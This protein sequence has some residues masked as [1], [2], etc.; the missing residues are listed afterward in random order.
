MLVVR[1][2]GRRTL[3]S[4]KPSR[5]GYCERLAVLTPVVEESLGCC[6]LIGSQT[7]Q[8]PCC[9]DELNKRVINLKG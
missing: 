6:S 4:H 5:S 8:G 1:S 9:T 3:Q 7:R 2:A